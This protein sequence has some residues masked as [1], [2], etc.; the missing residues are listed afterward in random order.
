MH[1]W[2]CQYAVTLHWYPLLLS[3]AA[4][5]VSALYY[6]HQYRMR[7]FSRV[8]QDFMHLSVRPDVSCKSHLRTCYSCNIK[9]HF[10]S[11]GILF[12]N[13]NSVLFTA[14]RNEDVPEDAWQVPGKPLFFLARSVL[15][16]IYVAHDSAT[17]ENRQISQV[18]YEVHWAAPLPSTI[19]A[20]A[21]HSTVGHG[22]TSIV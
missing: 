16:S 6:Y 9:T 5:W 3:Y 20:V 19:T 15:L 10:I 18:I 2:Q 12:K 11:G 14:F 8:I 13:Q 1:I 7:K 4:G 22:D 17:A 21:M